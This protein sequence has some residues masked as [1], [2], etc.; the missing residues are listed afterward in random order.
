MRSPLFAAL[1]LGINGV[2]LA[3]TFVLWP[4]NVDTVMFSKGW[5]SNPGSLGAVLSISRY[6]NELWT[7]MSA[8][9]LLVGTFIVYRLFFWEHLRGRLESTLVLEEQRQLGVTTL[10]SLGMFV[11]FIAVNLLNL[12]VHRVV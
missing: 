3:A 8:C 7:F 1:Y 6:G 9:L 5:H 12:Y 11:G 4:G 10:V 2:Y